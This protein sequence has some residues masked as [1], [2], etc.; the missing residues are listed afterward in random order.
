MLK[1]FILSVLTLVTFVTVIAQVENI[2]YQTTNGEKV[3]QLSITVPIQKSEA[4]K[5]FSTDSGLV[6]WMAPVAKIELKTG[7]YIKTN[8]D[9]QKGLKDKTTIRLDIVNFLREEL[10]TLKVNL[11]DKFPKEARKTDKNLQEILQFMDLGNGQT[12]IISSM[13]GWGKGEHWDKTYSFFEKGNIWTFQ[14]ILNL[15]KKTE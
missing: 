4:W 11:N 9:R 15:F 7:G 1:K 13:V 14:Q 10:M 3:L 6:K 12:K 5:L 2:S 8:Y